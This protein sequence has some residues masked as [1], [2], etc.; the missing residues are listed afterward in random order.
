MNGANCINKETTRSATIRGYFNSVNN[1]FLARNFPLPIAFDD[2]SNEATTVWKNLSLEEDI[3]NRR[4]PITQE[5]YVELISQANKEDVGSEPWLLSKVASVAKIV[6]PRTGEYA[7]NTQHKVEVHEYPSG[8]KVVKAWTR[9]DFAF[10]DKSGKKIKTFNGNTRKRVAKV[11]ITW[12]IQKNRRNGQSVTIVRDWSNEEVCPVLAALDIYMHSISIGQDAK[13]PMIAT[14]DKSN[15]FKYLTSNKTAS[16]LRQAARKVHPDLTENEYK[17]FS[18]HSFRVWACVLLSE[19]GAAPD[20]ICKRLRWE[21]DSYKL[22]LRDTSQINEQHRDHLQKESQAVMAML[23][24]NLDESLVPT[25][26][27]LDD[28]MGTYADIE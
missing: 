1:L 6:G 24:D 17:K 10:I 2:P 4:S 23:A 25:V 11:I 27:P 18:A 16:I 22:Y 19:A 12:R 28:N 8:K 3:A 21:G 13:L 9:Q 5:M 26:V 7:Q 14:L 15:K 20:F